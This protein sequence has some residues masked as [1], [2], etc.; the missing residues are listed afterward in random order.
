MLNCAQAQFI[1][2]PKV[3]G[4]Q[5]MVLME[6]TLHKLTEGD[7]IDHKD[8]LDRVDILCGLGKTVLISNYFEFHRLAAYL[9]RYTKQMIGLV[10]GVPTLK[11]IF[12]EKYY[13]DLEGGILESFGRMFKNDLRLYAYPFKDP[14]TGSIIT[15]G[16][17]RVAAHL[18]HLY[19]YLAENHCIQGLR[20]INE[21]LLPILSRNVLAKLRAGDATW[22]Y[23]VPPLVAEIIKERGLFQ[24]NGNGS[25]APVQTAPELLRAA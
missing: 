15:A 12:D 6:M 14:A 5:V 7:R 17:L 1:Q 20:D 11:E 2:E 23:M 24:Q 18:R 22:E 3:E 25:G 10:M 8:F 19:S 9:F 4:Q 21:S 13:K 16:N